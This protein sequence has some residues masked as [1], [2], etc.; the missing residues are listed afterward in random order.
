MP[1]PWDRVNIPHNLAVLARFEA[2][3]DDKLSVVTSTG[4]FVRQEAGF[5]TS[6]QRTLTPGE[7]LAND[8]YLDALRKLFQEACELARTQPNARDVNVES[9]INA[10]QGLK[11]LCATY[12]GDKRFKLLSL[13]Q[14][15]T[16][17]LPGDYFRLNTPRR[18]RADFALHLRYSFN[19]SVYLDKQHPGVCQ[20]LC[21]DWARR[22]LGT[23]S[24]IKTGYHES[25]KE[26]N[27]TSLDERMRKKIGGLIGVQTQLADNLTGD[28]LRSL[29][30]AVPK[31]AGLK[32]VMLPEASRGSRTLFAAVTSACRAKLQ[33]GA[34]NLP[35]SRDW[36]YLLG[37]LSH[38]GDG[39]SMALRFDPELRSHT[40]EG[41]VDF[42]DPNIGQFRFRFPADAERLGELGERLM[43]YYESSETRFKGCQVRI[44]FRTTD[45]TS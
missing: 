31:Y 37:F 14:K 16:D 13:F 26:D 42:F 33:F 28:R 41:D 22:M 45:P 43:A 20:A 3:R 38:D 24:K 10:W 21:L 1:K 30:A 32:T 8:Y 11:N 17:G 44:I 23:A 9:V 39:H 25:K 7:S 15:I 35:A 18:I 29:A 36:C 12:T 34:G 6:I 19:Q 27:P 4:Q 2:D 5:L 40:G